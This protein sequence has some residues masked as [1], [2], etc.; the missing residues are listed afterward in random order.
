MDFRRWV[1]FTFFIHVLVVVVD[2]GGGL[3]LYLLTANQADQ[4]GKSGIIASLP[5]V[6]MAVA[7]LG[8]ATSLV[9]Y[10]RKRVYTA[11][12]AFSTTLTVALIWGGFVGFLALAV[13]LWLLPAINPTWEFDPW[14]IVPFCVVVPILLIVSYGNSIQLAVERVRAYGAVHLITS[15]SFLPAF[16]LVFFWLGGKVED[17]DVPMAVAWGRLLSTVVIAVVV[18][19]L[20]SHV[21]RLRLGIHRPFLRDG[22]RFGW[23]ANLTSTLTYL[24]HR[25]DLIIL[26]ALFVP[27]LAEVD[28]LFGPRQEPQ[29]TLLRW[30]ESVNPM[31]ETMREDYY[32]RSVLKTKAVLAEVGFYGMAVTW[33]E[34]VWHFPEAMRDL[35]FSKVAGS[36]SAEARRMTPVLTRLGLTVSLVAGVAVV[37]L[38]DPVME[39]ITWIAGKEND[40]WRRIW[41]EPVGVALI[42]LTPG[43]VAYTVSKVLQA[44][45]A[46]RGHLHVCVRAQVV[47]LVTMIG[48]DILWMPTYGASGAALASTVAYIVS[49]MYTLWAYRRS[50]G[51][52]IWTCLIMHPSDFRYVGQIL[53]AVLAKLRWRR[54]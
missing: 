13:S 32:Q 5:F 24:N 38:V 41:S 20:V 30:N 4:H 29:D 19:W 40:P 46:A 2:K 16:F 45:L 17:G 11:Q 37:F 35:F 51:T 25:I 44:D 33:A 12:Q 21:V 14:L 26:G 28:V 52:A 49:T 39:T 48:L 53:N 31:P 54:S 15:L 7:N 43:T 9:F 50:T 23:K 8:L 10:L 42:L 1:V 6:L 27:T 3:I 36:T 22:L 18:I 34:L 47:V